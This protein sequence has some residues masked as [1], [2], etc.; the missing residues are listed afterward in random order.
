MGAGFYR[1]VG[2]RLLDLAMVLALSPLWLP[3][4]ALV[5]VLV[6]LRLGSPILFSQP[7]PGLRAKPFTLYKFRTM[8]ADRDSL[9]NLLPDEERLSVFGRFLRSTSLDE[10]P[11]LWNVL[12]GDMS[13]VGPRPLL[14]K[15]ADL[16]TPEQ[17]RR[18]EVKPGLTGWAQINGR[19]AIAWETKFQRDVWYVEHCSLWLDVKILFWT[20]HAVIRR[21]NVSANGHATVGEFQ[22]SPRSQSNTDEAIADEGITVIGA[23]GHAKVVVATLQAAGHRVS[24]V[25]DDRAELWGTSLLGIPIHGPISKLETQPWRRAVIAIGDN[26]I[27]RRLAGRLNAR[28]TTVVHPHALVDETARLGAGT[29]VFAG[30]VIQPDVRIG[31]HAIINTASSVDHDCVVGDFVHVAPGARLAGKVRLESDVFMGMGSSV[32]PGVTIGQRSVV[33]AGAVVITD[34]PADVVAVGVP[35]RTT[36]RKLEVRVA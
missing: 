9:G 16:Y 5:A 12:R 3:L 21:D 34:L 28:W 31:D 6:R 11:E 8:R 22:G 35:A 33:G 20:I 14:T 30:A 4:L 10:L 29:V 13:L 7:R 1:A 27:R 25:F 24:A 15:Y 23:G 26:S 18:H 19:N 32:I 17:S 36:R 2:K